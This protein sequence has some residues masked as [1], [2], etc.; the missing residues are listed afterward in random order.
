VNTE[1]AFLEDILARPED[2][3]PRLIYADWLEENGGPAERARAEFIRVQFALH[4]L[5]AYDPRRAQLEEHER[6]LRLAHEAVWVAPLRELGGVGA[7]V[8]RRGFV[9]SVAVWVGAFRQQADALFRLAPVCEIRLFDGSGWDQTS[10]RWRGLPQETGRVAEDVAGSP[11]LARLQ[12]LDLQGVQLEEA[13]VAALVASP[14]LG[15]LTTL[16]QSRRGLA[17][18]LRLWAAAPLL[19]RLTTFRLRGWH[20]GQGATGVAELLSSPALSGLRTLDLADSR[21]RTAEI[22]AVAGSPHL[23]RLT[24]L[25][26][27]QNSLDLHDVGRL[28]SA[29]A[30][31]E[32]RTLGLNHCALDDRA[33]RLLAESPLLAGLESLDLGKNR[34]GDGGVL[35]LA[36]SPHLGRLRLLD[37]SS[38][39]VGPEG[40]RN[41]ARSGLDRLAALYL[42]NNR[43][44]DD[45]L[46]ALALVAPGLPNLES[47]RVSYNRIGARGV[48]I[49]AAEGSGGLTTLDLSW[50]PVGDEG[51]RALAESQALSRLAALDLGYAELGDGAARALAESPHLAGLAVLNLCTNRIGPAGARALAGSASLAHLTALNLGYNAVGEEGVQALTASP[52]FRRLEALHLAGNG[53]TPERVEVL[54]RD[55][56]GH[57]GG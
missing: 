4:N 10:M 46:A 42:G 14:H 53:V 11:H 34:L 24:A 21:V 41:V 52:L 23:G 30:R 44:G 39:A 7:W 38:N 3:G 33:A 29:P 12:A 36:R 19:P 17:E 8:F 45:G 1:D 27:G 37:L 56:R 13:D 50:N 54:R 9:E 15:R 35:A 2:D 26:L 6:N 51:V 20:P 22:E 32:L 5:P 31:A 49:F 28:A 25:L 57:L 47:L 55:F 18:S 16:T 43:L 40:A 48:T